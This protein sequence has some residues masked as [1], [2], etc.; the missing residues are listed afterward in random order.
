MTANLLCLKNSAVQ[1]YFY[2]PFFF[3]CLL[4]ARFSYHW[5]LVTAREIGINVFLVCTWW[6]V[7]LMSL[8]WLPFSS[9]RRR[10]QDR[11][12]NA[13]PSPTE[14]MRRWWQREA[15]WD[16]VKLNKVWEMRKGLLLTEWA[17]KSD[18]YC[19]S[20]P[21]S[22]FLLIFFT[23]FSI[24]LAHLPN[25]HA[26]TQRNKMQNGIQLFSFHFPSHV[27]CHLFMSSLGK[28]KS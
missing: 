21:L 22:L 1:L 9:S 3:V 15:F 28:R 26:Q 16:I 20:W 7:L 2:V 12:I 8:F 24:Y 13:A 17:V 4:F 11:S 23:I 27:I 10:Q 14:E 6:T 18:E 5:T 25:L 19:C